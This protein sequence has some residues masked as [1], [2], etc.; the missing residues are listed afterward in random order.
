[1]SHQTDREVA[2]ATTY[3]RTLRPDQPIVFLVS[4]PKFTASDRSIR[5]TLPGDLV[6][7]MRTFVGD[8]SDLLAGHPTSTVL[9]SVLERSWPGV[10]QII[11]QDYVAIWIASLNP[12]YPAPEGSLPIAPGVLEVRGPAPLPAA[13]LPELSPPSSR[14]L[15]S[16]VAVSLAVLMVAGLGWA[17]G[18]VEG[19]WLTRIGLAPAFGAAFLT[20]AGVVSGQAGWRST[21]GE[22]RALILAVAVAGWVSALLILRARRRNDR[23]VSVEGRPPEPT[24]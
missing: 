14:D 8:G 22:G 18:L 16:A 1:M 3:L 12:R 5:A 13:S 4:T 24:P 23:A 9:S 15:V 20:L 10:E 11:D 2:A 6:S 21:G 7:R 17:G 19:T